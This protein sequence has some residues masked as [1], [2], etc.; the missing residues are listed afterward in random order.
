MND[1]G[2]LYSAG[3]GLRVRAVLGRCWSDCSIAAPLALGEV[4][5]AQPAPSPTL[6]KREKLL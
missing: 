4:P 3:G 6:R 1:A 5:I 2:F